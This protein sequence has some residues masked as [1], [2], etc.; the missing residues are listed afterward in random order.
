MI[1]IALL[2]CAY[3]T[4]MCQAEAGATMDSILDLTLSGQYLSMEACRE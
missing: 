2:F 3:D 1:D 4:R